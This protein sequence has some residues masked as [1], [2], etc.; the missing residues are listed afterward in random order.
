MKQVYLFILQSRK[1]NLSESKCLA[2]DHPMHKRRSPVDHLLCVGFLSPTW[3]ANVWSSHILR[4][5]AQ[6]KGWRKMVN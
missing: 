4:R 6:E 5:M 1:L 3:K 2:P